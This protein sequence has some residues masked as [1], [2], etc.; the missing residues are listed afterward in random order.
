MKKQLISLLLLVGLLMSMM[1][2]SATAADGIKVGDVEND[3]VIDSLDALLVLKF[4]VGLEKL[5]SIQ[6]K[7][8]DVDDSGDIDSLDALQILQYS[9][10]V[11]TSFEAGEYVVTDAVIDPV[12]LDKGYIYVIHSARALVDANTGRNYDSVRLAACIQGL[13]NR[14]F[15]RHGVAVA[16]NMDTTDASW[17][18]YISQ[19]G[20]TYENMEKF[21]IRTQDEF[22]NV[23]EPFMKQYGLIV[24]DPEVPSTANVASTICGLDG[25]L[26]VQYSEDEGSLYQILTNDMEIP[27]K[28][29]LVGMFDGKQGTK[30]A[31]TDIDSTG[32]AKNDAYLWAMEKYM[33]RCNT[34]WLAYTLDGASSVPTNPVYNGRDAY[35]AQITGIPNHDYFVSNKCFFFDLTSYGKEAPNDDPNQ[36]LGTDAATL[37]KILQRRY[38]LAGGKFG[39]VLGFPPWHV[40]YTTHD[41]NG[42][43]EAPRLEWHFVEVCTSYNCGIEADAAQ[44]CWM[45]NASLYANYEMVHTPTANAPAKKATYNDTTRY[46]TFTWAG[47]Y[48]C[49]PW[50]KARA[51]AMWTDKNLGE[52]PYM[53]SVNI[54]LIDRVPM[55]FDIMYENRTENDYILAAEGMGYVTPSALF[56][57][58]VGKE[59]DPITRT[60]PSGDKEYLAYAKP[61]YDFLKL[62]VS[63]R[64][65]NGFTVMEADAMEVYNQTSPRG[66]FVQNSTAGEHDLRIYDGTPYMRMFG[67]SG[68]TNEEKA[69]NMFYQ[70]N[71]KYK[72]GLNFMNFEMTTQDNYATPTGIMEYTRAY[73]EYVAG[74][75]PGYDVEYVDVNTFL[76]LLK[77][78]GQGLVMDVIE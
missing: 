78:S 63:S 71:E 24:W 27:V 43:L 75:N 66:N 64:I 47:D 13:I 11:I 9:V 30:I 61:Y 46:Y 70:Q 17:L 19:D 41:G 48:D 36:P 62:D 68:T 56:Q 32:S 4:N 5:S 12:G 52:V 65:I 45:S 38:D 53:F 49:S 39:M 21:D 50:L 44:P 18:K 2:P 37:K 10:G 3:N 14:D 23:F 26:P 40:K 16:L 28:Q 22:L 60:L 72:K 25:Y 20:R 1:V 35:N 29:N 67:V 58:F 57:G 6:Q 7:A 77:Q 8:A 59:D 74:K 76:D 33:D 69:A 54:N 42:V 15:D 34:E 51:Q 73:E 31:D 55:C